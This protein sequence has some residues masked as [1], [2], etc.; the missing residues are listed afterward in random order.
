MVFALHYKFL[1]EFCVF[2]GK[3]GQC[4]TLEEGANE[5]TMLLEKIIFGPPPPNFTPTPPM[6]FAKGLPG[7]KEAGLMAQAGY[8]I[9]QMP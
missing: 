1:R 5:I 6:G 3:F 2:T 4:G 7:D 9:L 8:P